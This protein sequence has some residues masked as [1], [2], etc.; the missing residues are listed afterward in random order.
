[1]QTPLERSL[2]NVSRYDVFTDRTGENW[3]WELTPTLVVW[4]F[5][6]TL[7][8]AHREHCGP[9]A[10]T[11]KKKLGYIGEP[12]FNGV[13]EYPLT[14]S[15]NAATNHPAPALRGSENLLS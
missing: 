10:P 3:L 7:R 1:M 6:R 9:T 2:P 11:I 15:P 13:G 14:R 4:S 8:Y 12:Y 5:Q